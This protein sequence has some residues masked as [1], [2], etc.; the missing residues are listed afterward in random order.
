[1]TSCVVRQNF[2]DISEYHTPSIF[3]VDE[4]ASNE[5]EPDKK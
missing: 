3:K 1:M 5:K 2:S 4:V